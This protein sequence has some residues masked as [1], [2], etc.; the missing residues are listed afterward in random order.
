VHIGHVFLIDDD[1]SL[2]HS[3]HDLLQF[4]GY[5]THSWPDAASFLAQ[6]PNAVPAVVIT[7]MRMPGLNGL[8]LHEALKAQGRELPVIYL[9]G[10]SSL[11]QGIEAMKLGAHE[12]LIKPV[13]REALLKAV[14]SGLEKDRFQMQQMLLRSRMEQAVQHLSPREREVHQ[15]ML[16][17]YG[18]AE[19]V[20]ALGIS[21]PTAKQ[22]KSEVMR[23]LGVRSL[24]Q[25]IE[26]SQPSPA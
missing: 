2:R 13:G 24:S 14:A 25:L 8:Q 11:Q 21:L 3:V 19:I 17:G 20:A 16:K 6:I 4:A 9:S 26:L 7:D 22:Y 18:N 5:R 10:E 15:L 12:F 1:E 23:K